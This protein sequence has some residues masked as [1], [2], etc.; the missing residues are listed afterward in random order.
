MRI[1]IKGFELIIH[2]LQLSWFCENNLLMYHEN[3]FDRV[4]FLFHSILEK[5]EGKEFDN[6]LNFLFLALRINSVILEQGSI[7][8]KYIQ[9]DNV[10]FIYAN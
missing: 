8:E 5:D 3:L 6:S 4:L 9:Q 7:V 2:N 1:N 10:L